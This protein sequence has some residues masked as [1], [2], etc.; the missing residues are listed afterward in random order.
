[1]KTLREKI[2]TWIFDLDNTLY[3]ADSGIFQQVSDLMGEF[4]SK[5]LNI[6]IVE[7]KKIQ[8]KYYKQHGTTLKGMMDNH[9]VDPD[10]FLEEVH[11]LDYSIV[12]PNHKLNEVLD[13]LEGRKIIYTNANLQHVDN[14]L[15]R[16]EL[17]NKF[18]E[19]YDIKAANYIPKPE[20]KPYK[21]FIEKFNINPNCSIMF[22]DIAK[23]LVPAKNVGFTSVWIDHG[24]EN[25][26]DDIKSSEKYLD[27]K[28]KDLSLFLDKVNKGEI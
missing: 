3:A 24:Y 5:H 13:K 28:T 11:K 27:Y 8:S 9:G 25:F 21:K 7:A 26:S 6:D 4:V 17:L 23:N 20:I 16:L 19:I 22:D 14:V 2:D 15:L 10:L 12:G 18:D 1:M